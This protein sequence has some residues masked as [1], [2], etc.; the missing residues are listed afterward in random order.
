MHAGRVALPF[1]EQWFQID[2]LSHA[3]E[4]CGSLLSVTYSLDQISG[5]ANNERQVFSLIAKANFG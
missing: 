5:S 1:T 3:H 4:S 2:A